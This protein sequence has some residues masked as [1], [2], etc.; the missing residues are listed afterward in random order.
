[1]DDK[2]QIFMEYKVK[3]EKES[4]YREV[5]AEI[6]AVLPT[7]EVSNFQWFSAF[8]QDG[9]FVEM[10]EVPTP[11][12][13]HTLKKWRTSKSHQVFSKLDE[14][15]KGGTEKIHCWAFQAKT[16]ELDSRR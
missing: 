8:D 15:V 14:C 3:P 4:L 2:L 1:M 7:Y 16:D 10:F 5:M 13:Y 11:S 9:L 6:A 12:H